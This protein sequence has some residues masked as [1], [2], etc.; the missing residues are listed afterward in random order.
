MTDTAEALPCRRSTGTIALCGCRRCRQR[1]EFPST[2]DKLTHYLFRYPAKFHPPL[3]RKLIEQYSRPGDRILDPFVGSGTL[4]VEAA[5]TGR[6][7][8]GTDIDPVAV[9]VAT[10]KTHAYNTAQL[11]QSASMLMGRL[12]TLR[13]APAEYERRMFADLSASHATRSV[14]AE[15]L[16]IPNIPKIEH[17]FR[18]YVTIDLARIAKAIETLEAPRTHKR[19]FYLFFASIIRN[20]SNADPV[21]V[22]GLEVTSHMRKKDEQGRLIDPFALM[23]RAMTAGLAAV[24]AFSQHA[25]HVE[26]RAKRGDALDLSRLLNQAIDVVITSPPYH[27]AVDYYRRHMLEMYWLR[28]IVEREER[29][30][31]LP[32]Y[33]G[34]S[35]VR[36]GHRFMT[37]L[38]NTPQARG[39]YEKMAPISPRRANAFRHY[40]HSMRDAMRELA[41]VLEPGKKAVFVLGHSRW[42]GTELPTSDLLEEVAAE[43][44]DPVE[45]LWYPVKNRYMSYQRRNGADICEEHVLV[46]KRRPDPRAKRGARHRG[47]ALR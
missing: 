43:W 9:F 26:V 23:M 25:Q 40:V 44:F 16:W 6:N 20:A 45:R 34:R 17:W 1:L 36:N 42:Q 46:L 30:A 12:R 47:T 21:P 28:L 33:I 39:W 15:R 29:L 22:S 11:A 38:I 31:L 19:L 37:Q 24:A 2:F 32:K 13:R 14:N 7:A 35:Q 4:L 10:V 27:N 3:V 5:V 8:I 41:N 18:R